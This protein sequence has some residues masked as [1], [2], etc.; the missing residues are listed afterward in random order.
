MVDLIARLQAAEGPDRELDAEICALTAPDIGLHRQDGEWF[1][2]CSIGRGRAVISHYT[3]SVDAA[4]SLVPDNLFWLAGKARIQPSEPL[5][6][7]QL[8][9][10]PNTLVS[11]GEHNT[12]VAIA[13]C[14]AA[15]K[16]GGIGGAT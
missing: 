2:D 12:S 8:I 6:G 14:I 3:A 5:Y 11:E 9:L 7:A 1:Y 13:L 15:L 16:A 10:P 4:L